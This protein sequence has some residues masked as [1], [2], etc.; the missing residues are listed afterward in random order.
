MQ[1]E[2]L[3]PKSELFDVSIEKHDVND[4]Q[5]LHAWSDYINRVNLVAKKNLLISSFSTVFKLP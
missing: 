3:Q 5:L 4:T 2:L 1:Y